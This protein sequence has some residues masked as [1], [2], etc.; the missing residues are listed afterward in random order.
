M[1]G[2]RYKNNSSVLIKQ[3]EKGSYSPNFADAQFLYQYD[4]SSKLNISFLGSFNL[5]QFK[6]VPTNRETQ[7]G[8]LSTTLRLNVDYTGQEIDDYQTAG[9]AVTA[10][11]SPKPNLVIKFI[12]SYFSTIERERFDINGSYIFDEVD[13]TF[14]GENFGV[15]NKNRGIGSYYNYG[16]NS[17]KYPNLC[18]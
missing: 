14:S 7:F 1:A 8:T 16:R 3:D 12:N 2:L 4:F 10:T 18:F 9:S 11:Y 17:F 6:L 15:I 5:G 13:N